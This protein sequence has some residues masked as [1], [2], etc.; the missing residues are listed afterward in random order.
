MSAGDRIAEAMILDMQ[1]AVRRDRLEVRKAALDAAA[2]WSSSSIPA[3]LSAAEAFEAWLLRPTPH[4]VSGFDR[5]PGCDLV[6]REP[7][8]DHTHV[9][10]NSHAHPPHLCQTCDNIYIP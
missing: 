9:C 3:L 4:D 6:W 5:P 7:G 8:D 10:R 1:A 2:R